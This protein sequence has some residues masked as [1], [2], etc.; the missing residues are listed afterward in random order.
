MSQSGIEE[1]NR[2]D[3]LRIIK[4]DQLV[5]DSLSQRI[6]GLIRENIELLALLQEAQGDAAAHDAAHNGAH[7]HPHEPAREER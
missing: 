6:A 7:D 4:R 5:K 3:L 2:E 1:F